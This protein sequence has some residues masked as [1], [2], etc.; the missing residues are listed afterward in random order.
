MT[1]D[2]IEAVAKAIA[3]AEGFMWSSPRFPEHD[4]DN[5]TAWRDM[6]RA[7]I[8]AMPV[9]EMI[10]QEREAWKP[11][12][13]AP[14]DGT[15]FVALLNYN[16]GAEPECA[17]IRWTGRA[18][19]PWYGHTEGS[20]GMAEWVPTHWLPLPSPPVQPLDEPSP[21]ASKRT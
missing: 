8:A 1:D 13:S 20:Q 9:E 10:R 4:A 2:A 21:Q 6:A 17:V 18:N 15:T 3:E 11:I 7:A 5:Q 19:F 12:S 16:D 14:K